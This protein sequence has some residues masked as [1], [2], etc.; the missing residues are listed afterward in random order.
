M[1]HAQKPNAP[2]T[3]DEKRF[4]RSNVT[5]GVRWLNKRMPWRT[6]KA[7]RRELE[8]LHLSLKEPGRLSDL[9]PECHEHYVE[10]GSY[11]ARFGICM[12]C[13]YRREEQRWLDKESATKAK[14][15]KE[16]ARQRYYRA[17]EPSDD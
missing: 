11:G 3:D 7:I 6:E 14:A 13:Y 15:A 5:K 8:R 9:C 1:P 12:T 4:L 10:P 2:W 16:A 17:K